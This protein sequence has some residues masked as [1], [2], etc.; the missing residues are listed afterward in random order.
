[1]KNISEPIYASL[2]EFLNVL[3]GVYSPPSYIVDGVTI[4]PA[5]MAGVDW[6]YMIRAL[7]FIVVLYSL[8]RLIGGLLCRQK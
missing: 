4:I 7:L 8:F 5:G 1:M 2:A 6:E 3:L